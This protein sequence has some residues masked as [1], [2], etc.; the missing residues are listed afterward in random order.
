MP[1]DATTHDVP[2]PEPVGASPAQRV[3]DWCP[4]ALLLIDAQHDFWSEHLAARFP[5][6]PANVARLLA[7]CR[8]EGIEVIHLRVRF[9]PDGSDWMVA[10]RLR[11]SIPCVQGTSGADTL[12]FAREHPGEAVVVKQSYDGFQAA[13]LPAYL[14]STGK[15]F[16]L[17]AG[18][19]TSVCVLFTTAAAAQRGFLT[20]VVEDCCADRPEAHEQTLDRYRG[21][22]FRRTTVDRLLE[23]H[24]AWWDALQKVEA[25]HASMVA[26][27]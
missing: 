12:P 10:A 16:L 18:L 9:R 19:V 6:F 8:A 23:E 2:G 21:L 11:G 5:E 14:R 3:R 25:L 26:A 20:A 22:I 4:F 15:R 24:S 17:T 1:T 27:P 7:L 13:E